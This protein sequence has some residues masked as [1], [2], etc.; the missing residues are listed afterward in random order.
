VKEKKNFSI[1]NFEHE[2]L[3]NFNRNGFGEIMQRT[4]GIW[5]TKCFPKSEPPN[6]VELE[7]LCKQLG[8]KNVSKA[9]GR[10]ASDKITSTTSKLDSTKSDLNST[11][12]KYPIEFHKLN[13]TK[14]VLYSKFSPVKLND[15]FTVHMKTSKPLAKLVHWDKTDHDNCHRLELQCEGDS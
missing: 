14:I 3:L 15:V 12:E 6:Q 1:K 13:A 7:E 11:P 2:S 10:I 8:F 5:H 9:E 4:Y